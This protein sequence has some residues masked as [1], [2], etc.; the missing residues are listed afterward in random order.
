M[1][2]CAL[3][4]WAEWSTC[5]TECGAHT[6]TRKRIINGEYATWHS[7]TTGAYTRVAEDKACPYIKACP[8]TEDPYF[9]YRK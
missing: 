5:S 7:F 4:G 3:G 8:N 9:D 1:K 2:K 6:Q